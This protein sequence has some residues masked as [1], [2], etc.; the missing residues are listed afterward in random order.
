MDRLKAILIFSMLLVSICGVFAKQKAFLVGVSDYSQDPRWHDIHGAEDVKLMSAKL[1]Q[2]GFTEITALVDNRATYSN[3]LKGWK[4]F[5]SQLKKG[6]VA[7]VHFSTHGQ[8]FEDYDGD[9]VDGWDESIVPF[10]AGYMFGANYQG[11]H[12][13][14]D[15]TISVY[16]KRMREKVGPSGFVYLVLD[17]CHSGS[18][19][20]GDI[21]V[22][23]RGTSYG[24][25]STSKKY[26]FKEVVQKN[27][28]ENYLISTTSPN[29]GEVLVLSAC[30]PHQLNREVKVVDGENTFNYGSLSYYV[31]SA[32]ANGCKINA[33]KVNATNIYKYV[34]E[35]MNKDWTLRNQDIDF[36]CSFNIE[37]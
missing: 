15:D 21:D 37:K 13:I 18:G 27:K 31:A 36:N 35:G 1:K 17:A 29:M 22:V 20:R 25:S 14:I 33:S 4:T 12:H 34:K 23:T 26:D 3:I 32:L 9:E 10:D 6:D 28:V 11:Q 24:F 30:K 16:V 7:Y 2:V 19:S 5:I 8:P